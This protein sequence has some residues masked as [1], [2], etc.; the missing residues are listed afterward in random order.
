MNGTHN[1]NINTSL[2]DELIKKFIESMDKFGKSFEEIS[3]NIRSAGTNFSGGKNENVNNNSRHNY[4]AT[5]GYEQIIR[6]LEKQNLSFDHIKMLTAKPGGDASE[7]IN[8]VGFNNA[9]DIKDIQATINGLKKI[10]IVNPDE[11]KKV[12]ELIDSLTLSLSQKQQELAEAQTNTIEHQIM[13][14][15]N[16][17]Q[18]ELDNMLLEQ[19]MHQ[20]SF[21]NIKQVGAE[22]G[23]GITKIFENISPL[24]RTINET[25]GGM[26][27]TAN[28]TYGKTKE[29]LSSTENKRVIAAKIRRRDGLSDKDYMAMSDADRKKADEK[30]NAMADGE[31]K[32]IAAQKS[33]TSALAS[34]AQAIIKS[35]SDFV[36]NQAK[37]AVEMLKYAA[38]FSSAATQVNTTAINQQLETGLSRSDNYGLTMALKKIGL[39]SYD[40]YLEY[41]PFM[42]ENQKSIFNNR[43]TTASQQ[44]SEWESSGIYDT[45][46]EW[47]N[48]YEDFQY[49]MQ[50]A[51]VD[52][53]AENRS[54]IENLMN[55]LID[56]MPVI[57][58][59][60]QGI[61]SVITGLLNL[62]GNTSSTTTTADIIKNYSGGSG[63]AI[64]NN[65]TVSH[66][67]NKVNEDAIA[68]K[69]FN[70]KGS[71]TL[72]S[73][74]V[75]LLK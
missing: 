50:L 46:T 56:A 39:N 33:F 59:A 14:Q 64:T 30:Y 35:C 15:E 55:S 19:E 54:S 27:K 24:F 66:T 71:Q 52:F 58:S 69:E 16:L 38:S 5:A 47:E 53:F 1:I 25:I 18:L 26:W 67:Y 40:E 37:A 43:L 29:K 41:L 61:L 48:L 23:S 11:R 57:L 12:E 63:S 3:G 60:L 28:N 17:A 4:N 10:P 36:A 74:I 75:N 72:C 62:F 42:T 9:E 32:A 20:M 34:G 13:M 73:S 2:N 51:F 68:Y 31:I 49:D 22:L 70:D 6:T 44:Y 7:A 65:V 45:I 21:D 8:E